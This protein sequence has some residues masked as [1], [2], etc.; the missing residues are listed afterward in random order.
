MSMTFS[1]LITI[2]SK[3]VIVQ[4]N[5]PWNSAYKWKVLSSVRVLI[6]AFLPFP[7][8]RAIFV[9]SDCCMWMINKKLFLQK[10]LPTVSMTKGPCYDIIS[11]EFKNK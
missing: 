2:N 10:D 11:T 5:C 4:Q 3:N 8:H 7:G 9:A 6:E 1:K